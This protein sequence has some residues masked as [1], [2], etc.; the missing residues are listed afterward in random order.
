MITI[1]II[2]DN[3]EELVGMVKNSVK[4][5]K[6]E[7]DTFS[8]SIGKKAII[9]EV[10]EILEVLSQSFRKEQDDLDGVSKDDE[11]KNY[12]LIESYEWIEKPFKKALRQL[13]GVV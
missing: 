10:K 2:T 3:Y 6:A 12:L 8:R 11:M 5:V 1:K 9:K 7:G 4:K 13:E